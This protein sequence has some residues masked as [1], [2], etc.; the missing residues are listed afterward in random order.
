VT[1]GSARAT[2][3]ERLCF[4]NHALRL[5]EHDE[6]IGALDAD[7]S[8]LGAWRGFRLPGRSFAHGIHSSSRSNAFTALPRNDFSLDTE[9]K[10]V[11]RAQGTKGCSEALNYQQ[12]QI[13]GNG[14]VTPQ[15]ILLER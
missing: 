10:F 11:N 9:D 6:V 1:A 7:K 15:F 2:W 4:H 3:H 12:I 8:R 14:V 13:F 5:I